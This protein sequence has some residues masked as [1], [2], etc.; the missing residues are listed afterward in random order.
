MGLAGRALAFQS[1]RAFLS[2]LH[3]FQEHSQGMDEAVAQYMRDFVRARRHGLLLTVPR[4]PRPREM[5]ERGSVEADHTANDPSQ[6]H[7]FFFLRSSDL[8]RAEGRKDRP[9][10]AD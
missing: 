2:A 10:E 1:A 9:G 4:G 3:A 7:P 5:P 6:N 8:T